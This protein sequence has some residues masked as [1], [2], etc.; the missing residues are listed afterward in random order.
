M[1]YVWGQRL[2]PFRLVRLRLFGFLE[3]P[4]RFHPR[5]PRRHFPAHSPTCDPAGGAGGRLPCPR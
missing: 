1:V 5:Y 4:E 3:V 2:A